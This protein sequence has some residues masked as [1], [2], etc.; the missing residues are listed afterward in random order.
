MKLNITVSYGTQLDTRELDHNVWQLL[1]PLYADIVINGEH[2]E[3]IVPEGFTTDFCSVPRVPFAYTLFGGKYN[4]TG[5]L[6]DALYSDWTHIKIIHA[7]LRYEQPITRE[8]AD[9]ILYA[10]LI[11]EGATHFTAWSMYQGVNV[12]GAKYYQR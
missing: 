1:N 4:R 10:S 3:C 12:F 8:L 11:G 7:A 2:Y 9:K 6:H 5:T